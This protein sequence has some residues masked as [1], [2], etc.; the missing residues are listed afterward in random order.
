MKTLVLTVSCLALA[1]MAPP[2]ALY[3][4][5]LHP[6]TAAA[7][8]RYVK[9]TESRIE[10]E[11]RGRLPFLWVDRLP[12]AQRRDA[13]ARLRRGEIVVSRLET[14][15]G[16]SSIKIP[17]GLCHHWVGTVLI[18]GVTVDRVKTLMQSYDKYQQ[19]YRPAVRQSRTLSHDGD[20]FTVYLQLFMKK[21]VSVVLN[22]NN[23]VNYVTK[24]PK[25]VQVRSATTR[26]AEV[27]D[28][29]TPQEKELPVGHDGGYLW[30]F[31]NYCALE[32]RGEG[33]YVQCESVSLTRSIPFGLGWVVG[34]FVTSIPKE[35][36]EFTL[37]TMRTTLTTGR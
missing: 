7:F 17:D 4:A 28:A 29:D 33:T 12:E 8:D 26:V 1:A 30:R 27:G 3:G 18:P 19:I 13:D 5:D 36:L 25:Q 10:E 2:A 6:T 21:V 35:S 15:D 23:D 22:T 37:G 11:L 14:R 20:H 32:E 31:N 16:A 24:T 9:L 34:P